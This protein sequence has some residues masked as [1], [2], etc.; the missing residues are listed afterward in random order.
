MTHDPA[1][2]SRRRGRAGAS[3]RSRIAP[4]SGAPPPTDLGSG[5]PR[6]R[7]G[8]CGRGDP[9]ARHRAPPERPLRP[10]GP[11]R[12]G[13]ARKVAR[14][15]ANETRGVA[16]RAVDAF[17]GISASVLLDRLIRGRLW[18]GLLAFALI[19]IVAMQLIV[20]K[21]NTGIGRTLTRVAQ[22]QREN[23][24]LGIEDSVYSAEARV[25]PLATAD[26]MTFAPSGAVHFVAAS[27]ADVTRAAAALST[28]V[29]APG[30]AAGSTSTAFGEASGGSGSS[31][32]AGAGVETT[33]G[34]EGGAS[35]SSTTSGEGGGSGE[36]SS[37][38]SPGPEAPA[39]SAGR[40]APSSASSEAPSGGSQESGAAAAPASAT[41]AVG[42]PASE[43]GGGVQAGVRE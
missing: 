18:I 33:R 42:A 40:P 41:A 12:R 38:A 39:S 26:G 37:S 24:Q 29:Q 7:G 5:P 6:A 21:L 31:Q 2:H 25:E 11:P 17:E 10:A 9:G 13:P 3:R 8:R 32:S 35:S 20:L 16:L 30:G 4:Q 34:S 43:P 28:A 1:R 15:P 22:L 27:P 23:A 19:G 36:P 14:R